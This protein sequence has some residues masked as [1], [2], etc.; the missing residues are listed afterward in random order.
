M[1]MCFNK[2]RIGIELVHRGHLKE[3]MKGLRDFEN[4][5][6]Y[7]SINVVSFVRCNVV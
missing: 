4:D 5:S 3:M 1:C 6:Y 2:S 7:K